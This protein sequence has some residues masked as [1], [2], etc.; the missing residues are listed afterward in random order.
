MDG[1][2]YLLEDP[3]WRATMEGLISSK[4][5]QVPSYMLDEWS[6]D[7]EV[8]C[9]AEVG[10]ELAK[11]EADSKGTDAYEPKLR[12]LRRISQGIRSKLS[13]A[14]TRFRQESISM[15]KMSEWPDPESVF[16]A[17]WLY[18]NVDTLQYYMMFMVTWLI[19]DK[20]I[21]EISIRLNEP[22]E[23]P[24]NEIRCLCMQVWKSL[25]Y[26][27]SIGPIGGSLF[28]MVLCATIEPGTS[29]ERNVIYDTILDMDKLKQRLPKDKGELERIL[30]NNVDCI[31]GKDPSILATHRKA[32]RMMA[33]LKAKPTVTPPVVALPSAATLPDALIMD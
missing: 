31:T 13:T 1:Q 11:I 27:R 24:T 29:E 15:G 8:G 14:T 18:N 21:G 33:H 5:P 12:D 16:G 9:W 17:R 19:V 7:H 20:T 28:M 2:E 4:S 22:E 23:V 25:R 3:K 26:M 30:I 32:R 6:L 10:L